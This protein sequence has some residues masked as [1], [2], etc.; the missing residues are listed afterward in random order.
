MSDNF[1]WLGLIALMAFAIFAITN[2]H[3]EGDNGAHNE[4]SVKLCAGKHCVQ[5]YAV[6]Y[7]TGMN[8]AFLIS[9][10]EDKMECAR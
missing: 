10:I 7:S 1:I 2:T 3:E 8:C 6:K 9:D 5:T 4:D